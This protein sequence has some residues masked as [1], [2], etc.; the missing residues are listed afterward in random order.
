MVDDVGRTQASLELPRWAAPAGVWPLVFVLA[1]VVLPLAIV[2]GAVASTSG[3]RPPVEL[4]L[5]VALSSAL[6]AS[7]GTLFVLCL[8]LP[9]TH[10]LT[11]FQF[12]GRQLLNAAVVIPFLLPTVVTG[13]AL[14]RLF[15]EWLTPGLGLVLI[16]HVYVNLAVVVRL[17]GPTW[18]VVDQR[19]SWAAQSLGASRWRLFRSVWWPAVRPAVFSSA[20]IVW[21]YC[22]SS[23]GLMLILGGGLR[24][25]D[26]LLLR[27]A[28]LL[29]DFRSAAVTAVLQFIIIALVL[30]VAARMGRA[31]GG[32]REAAVRSQ[33]PKAMRWVPPVTTL[34]LA[35]PLVQL[36]L[37]SVSGAQGWTLEWWRV[38][39]E[40]GSPMASANALEVGL[41]SLRTAL[42]AGGIGTSLALAVAIS[43]IGGWKLPARLG[44]L[45]M[46]ISSVTLGLGFVL[47]SARWPLSE[48]PRT[49]L[50]PL[51]HAAFATPLLMS[52]ALPAV[53]SA[54]PRLLQV[55]RSLG[56]S[57]R[58]ALFA[59]YGPALRRVCIAGFALSA[60][61]SLGE[62]G[63]ASF[64]TS[65]LVP[66]L[67]VEILRLMNRPGAGNIGT[68]AVLAT[69]LA[70]VSVGL[71]LVVDKFDRRVR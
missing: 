3:T 57:K 53:Q 63:M 54:D 43:A 27:Q 2:G 33:L 65:G 16:A 19:L 51:A 41:Q 49:W 61:I 62:Y 42:L 14:N 30:A 38:L 45:P 67:P 15:A 28:G 35:L 39:L 70:F 29:L 17:V 48:L 9:L 1:L 66:T 18:S 47:A 10:L 8:G 69:I 36:P 23:L 26:T 50:L 12:A 55:A 44:L 71:F 22:F 40:E 60:A 58:A 5:D 59:A 34:L 68:A 64:L 21:V 46:G 56:A 25:L 37:M 4:L 7:L 24:T 31:R 52:L 11:R 6:Q 32:F 13:L 20:A